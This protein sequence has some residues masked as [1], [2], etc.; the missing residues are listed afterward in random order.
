MKLVLH[1]VFYRIDCY[2]EGGLLLLLHL[3]D[4][5]YVCLRL[6]LHWVYRCN[7]RIGSFVLCWYLTVKGHRDFLGLCLG[8]RL[9]LLRTGF[10]HS[11]FFR[12]LL[13]C[14]HWADSYLFLCRGCFIPV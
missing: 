7:I 10:A 14:L 3:I 6:R 13:P 8:K 4:P 11:F 12:S 5:L 9:H 1:W 2:R